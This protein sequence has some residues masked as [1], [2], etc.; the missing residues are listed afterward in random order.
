MRRLAIVIG[1]AAAA[2]GAAF[3][4]WFVGLDPL[5]AIATVLVVGPVAAALATVSADDEAAWQPPVRETPRGTRITVAILEESL[6]ACDR[7]ARPTAVRQLR[8]LAIAERD[9]LLARSTLMRRLRALLVAELRA[10]GLDAINRSHDNAVVA[11]LGPDAFTILQPN[12]DHPVTT[13]AL[14]RCLDAVERLGTEPS[15]SR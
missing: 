11:L 14:T 7:L 9:D 15:R 10:R 4:V 1:S 6:L 12:G 8:A 3:G 2:G 13:A 5:W